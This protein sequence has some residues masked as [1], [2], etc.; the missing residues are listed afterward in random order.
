MNSDTSAVLQFS[1]STGNNVVTGMTSD[2]TIQLF[3]GS[4]S[5][6]VASGD[7][8]MMTIASGSLSSKVTLKGMANKSFS[9]K[10]ATTS[11][12]STLIAGVPAGIKVSGT[13]LTASSSFTGSR[14][15]VAELY[16]TGVT[17]INAT[18]LSQNVTWE[19]ND[20]VYGYRPGTTSGLYIDG[21]T[22]K[23]RAGNQPETASVE[24]SGLATTDGL[25]FNGNRLYLYPSN[26]SADGVSIVSNSGYSFYLDNGNYSD[27]T[28]TADAGNNTI[29]NYGSNIRI[30]GGAGSNGINLMKGSNMT[31]DA[32]A[33]S[34]TICVD[35]GQSFHVSGFDSN[36]VII[37]F[38]DF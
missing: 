25:K 29:Y 38:I 34:N 23:Y 26:F 36:D 20:G 28:F 17:K 19:N 14:I 8:V 35:G 6:A 9:I 3:S 1:P 21:K 7:D 31:I 15:D 33:G 24:L 2:D 22:L 4:V 5:S 13:T 11:A 32:A 30:N 37:T 18:A 16:A 27:K 10:T 12:Q